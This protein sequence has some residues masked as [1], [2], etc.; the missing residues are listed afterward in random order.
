M[1]A[2]VKPIS[3]ARTLVEAPAAWPA[4]A[5]WLAPE[6]GERDGITLSGLWRSL[7]RH[8]WLVI[9][10]AVLG[11]L[12]GVY[13]ALSATPMYR[14]AVTLSVEP[15]RPNLASISGPV[16]MVPSYRFYE[17]QAELI[18]SRVVAERVV[19]RLQLVDRQPLFN[20]PSSRREL[21]VLALIEKRAAEIEML[22]RSRLSW[23]PDAGAAGGSGPPA[24]EA[25][26]SAHRLSLA[27]MI[28]GNI[29]VVGSQNTQLLEVGYRSPDPVF[30]ADVANAAADAY[31]EF[32]LA[33]RLDRA[34]RASAWLTEQIEDLR[35]KV[36]SS[37]AAL[38][39][40]Q[41]QERLID[42][43][44]IDQL[45]D[46]RLQLLN[47]NV[48][49]AQTH[50]NDLAKRYG[51]KHPKMIEALAKLRDAK[52]RLARESADVVDTKEKQFQLAKLERDVATNRQL[53]DLFLTRF[54]EADSAQDP[55][56]SSARVV[57]A[58]L[59][60]QLP[61]EP[62]E[63]R[64]ITEWLL[65][66]L[67]VGLLLALT[68]E[69]LDRT[70]K[71]PSQVEEKLG[72]PTLAAV[73]L[74]HRK[75]LGKVQLSPT[76]DGQAEH[77]YLHDNRSSFA[78]A[79]NHVRTS[80]LYSN[81]DE[82]P[83][84]VLVS[85][86][87]QGEGKTT[88]AANLAVAFAQLGDTLLIDADLRKPRLAALSGLKGSAGLVEFV[89]GTGELDDCIITDERCPQ[90]C[91]LHAGVVPPNPLELLSSKR[92]EHALGQLRAR[93]SY[94]IVD[95]APVLPVSDAV[96]LGHLADTMLLVLHAGKTT[97]STAREMLTRLEQARIEPLGIVLS[98]V[99][100]R[101]SAYYYEGSEYY[102][103]YYTYADS[104]LA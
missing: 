64:I 67:M 26:R 65:I 81:V 100:H 38:Q 59:V 8:K 30:S 29:S 28:Q 95:T 90:L 66:G 43:Q 10:I 73:P 84:V 60:P 53:Y 54:K 61:Y 37:E 86:A 23:A 57:D 20:P 3:S 41:A 91:L 93:F 46:S 75:D 39:A 103:R 68:R 79:I 102:K 74:L 45:A 12:V 18:K 36:A 83:Q 22:V 76:R 25:Q 4:P 80:V 5:P 87:L 56:L 88:L 13:K 85:S 92:L 69:Y 89:A 47:D 9:L 40:F 48:L 33:A 34:E 72:V 82:P 98:Q 62:D 51:P 21:P 77:F 104:K 14:A 24:S 27:R 35:Q 17:T 58:A 1:A 78:E 6:T 101:K 97:Q 42:S 11:V 31:I 50:Y 99:D 63:P 19:D 71:T 15:D 55:K 16:V 7:R 32:G 96:V 2:N 70:L 52:Q 94:I 44:D 49:S